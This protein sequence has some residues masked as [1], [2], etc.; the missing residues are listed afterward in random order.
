MP[1]PRLRAGLVI[2]VG[3]AL[4]GP[5]SVTPATAAPTEPAPNAPGAS[6]DHSGNQSD[7]QSDNQARSSRRVAVVP[8]RN[9]GPQGIDVSGWQPTV[10]WKGWWAKGKRW[11]YIKATEGTTYKAKTF[12]SQYNG[13]YRTGY[14][15]GAYHYA[16]PGGKAGWRQADWFVANGGGW[17][18]DGKTLPGML[19]VEQGGK[20][21]GGI[22]YGRS[23][24][25]M[26]R[27]ITS[28]LNRYKKRTGRDAVIYTNAGFW[29]A[30]TGNTTKF[31]RTNPLFLARWN[32]T[33]G[34]TMPGGW[35]TWTF[36]QYTDT[37]LDQDMYNGSYAALK[38]FATKR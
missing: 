17:S 6:P 30:C 26:V 8:A 31:A 12:S 36:W 18:A 23:K 34:T 7:S 13:S 5:L 16:N 3:V 38:K 28:F 29:Q 33:P 37:P 21:D 2:A 19:D 14:I 32:T 25:R 10:D 20:S 1:L 24:A 27:W 15:R 11:A 22:C 4:L 9:Y 35:K